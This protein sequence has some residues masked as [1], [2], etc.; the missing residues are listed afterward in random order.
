[1]RRLEVS[2]DSEPITDTYVSGFPR[3]VGSFFPVGRFFLDPYVAIGGWDYDFPSF[4]AARV[5][6]RTRPCLENEKA[7]V[8][9]L[10]YC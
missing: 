9:H 7:M 3:L 10:G 5:S 1:L 2:R 4:V 6:Y 8:A